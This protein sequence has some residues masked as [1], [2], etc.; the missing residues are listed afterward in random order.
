VPVQLV[1]AR[2]VGVGQAA[3]WAE[4]DS[5]APPDGR[6]HVFLPYETL[7]RLKA[8][9]LGLAKHGHADRRLMSHC[10][11]FSRDGDDKS[12]G[13]GFAARRKAQCA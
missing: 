5:F 3:R 4:G 9:Q 10:A 7:R 2:F 6:L 13:G 12:A 1:L 11:G 8:A